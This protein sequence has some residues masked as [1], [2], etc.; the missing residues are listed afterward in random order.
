MA[1]PNVLILGHSEAA[2]LLR[3]RPADLAGI[4]SI[5][6][7]HE[8]VLE[9]P[10]VS[11]RLDLCFDDVE[12][13][14]AGDALGVLKAFVHRKWNEETGRPQ[15]PPTIDDARAIIEF[16]RSIGDRRGTLLCQCQ[17][18]VSRSPAA[19]LLCLA[20]W[21]GSGHEQECATEV[22][23]IRPCAMPH[24]GL[25]RIGDEVMGREGALIRAMRD[26]RRQQ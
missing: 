7:R 16:A 3:A 26:V 19:A 13:P 14:E 25:V 4:I 9:A 17:A 12:A 8:P 10:G 15:L 1:H 24:A 6:G 11:D 2:M 5:H 18:G 23:R 20:Q 22:L 21:R